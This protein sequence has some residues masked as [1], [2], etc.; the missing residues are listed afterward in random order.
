MESTIDPQK[1][2]FVHTSLI[3]GRPRWMVGGFVA[4]YK[5]SIF[6]AWLGQLILTQ[7][8]KIQFL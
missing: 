3:S 7:L 2:L 8:I 5:N 6:I 1:I 4:T